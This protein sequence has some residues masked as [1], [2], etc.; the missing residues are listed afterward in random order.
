[1]EKVSDFIFASVDALENG[2]DFIGR[3]MK[4]MVV[5]ALVICAVVWWNELS[6]FVAGNSKEV[7]SSVTK[8]LVDHTPKK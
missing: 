2:T 3:N 4:K 8:W 7:S 1:M 5:V 6:A